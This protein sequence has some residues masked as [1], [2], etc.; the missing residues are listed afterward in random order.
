MDTVNTEESEALRTHPRGSK[1]VTEFRLVETNQ[2]GRRRVYDS[3]K[4]MKQ[5][6]NY[7]DWYE[8]DPLERTAVIEQR[9]ITTTRWETA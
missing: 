1:T 4:T 3:I 9:T 7:R 2:S 8:H 5:A 6:A